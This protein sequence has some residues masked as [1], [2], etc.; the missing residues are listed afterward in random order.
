[1]NARGLP[2]YAF[3]LTLAENLPSIYQR[4]LLSTRALYEGIRGE[5]AL[6]TPTQDRDAWDGRAHRPRRVVLAPGVVINDQGPMPPNALSRCLV[7]LTPDAWY[8]LLNDRVFFWL[9]VARLTRLRRASRATSQAVL[10]VDVSR[11]LERHGTRAS[12][13]P[14]NTGNARRRA[15]SRGCSTFVPLTEWVGTR[16][17][18]EAEGL[19]TRVRPRSHRPVELTI[20]GSVPDL[21]AC[22][23]DVRLLVAG[24]L[25]G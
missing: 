16:W 25:F 10:T 19:G 6:G 20:E 5:R 1:M 11:L 14:I 9:D 7:G 3:H 21:A 18:T 13:A 12:V 17:A 23:L 2:P 22:L 4:G 8:A 15:A 24:E